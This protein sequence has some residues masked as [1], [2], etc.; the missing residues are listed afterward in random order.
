MFYLHIALVDI[1][2]QNI[3]PFFILYSRHPIFPIDSK[4]KLV[5]LQEID[6]KP[7][8]LVCSRQ[9]SSQFYQ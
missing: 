9:C 1:L 7:H 6:G 5:E 4:Y 8:D 3:L 2:Q